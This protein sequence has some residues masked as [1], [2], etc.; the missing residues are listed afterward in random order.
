[1]ANYYNPGIFDAYL[2]IY[3]CMFTIVIIN[4][5]NFH[6]AIMILIDINF[7]LYILIIY[8]TVELIWF[9]FLEIYSMMYIMDMI[10]LY[11]L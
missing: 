11:F 4:L 7:N 8:Y 9:V 5:I 10:F 1:M 3:H 6:I 2:N